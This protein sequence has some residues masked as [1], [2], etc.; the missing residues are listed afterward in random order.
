MDEGKEVWVGWLLNVTRQ[1]VYRRRIEIARALL[2]KPRLNLS[3]LVYLDANKWKQHVI[4][5]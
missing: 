2:N 4:Q 3:P 5:P 1:R